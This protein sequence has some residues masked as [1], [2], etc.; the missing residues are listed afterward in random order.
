MPQSTRRKGNE[1]NPSQ[2]PPLD[3]AAAGTVP[4]DNTD[5]F[6]NANH[7]YGGFASAFANTSYTQRSH[8][9]SGSTT[10]NQN[11]FGMSQFGM[12]AP[13]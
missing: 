1:T 6:N 10:F 3:F 4:Y 8:H 12:A 9:Q 5:P 7:G 11:P 2:M 13:G